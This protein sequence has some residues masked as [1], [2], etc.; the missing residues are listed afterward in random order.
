[1][2]LCCSTGE[3]WQQRRRLIT[4]TFHFDI[5]KA[6]LPIINDQTDILIENLIKKSKSGEE[7]DVFQTMSLLTLDIICGK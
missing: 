4:P 5:L 3:K 6:Y 7:I 1:M 2:N